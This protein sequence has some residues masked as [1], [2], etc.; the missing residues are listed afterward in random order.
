MDPNVI[1]GRVGGNVLFVV[2]LFL[3]KTAGLVV[4]SSGS[5]HEGPFRGYDS[6]ETGIRITRISAGRRNV[7]PG[8]DQERVVAWQPEPFVCLF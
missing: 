7:D 3:P 8:R 4:C 5:F 2:I 1:F 6:R